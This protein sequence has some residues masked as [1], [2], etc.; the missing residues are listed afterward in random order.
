[1]PLFSESLTVPDCEWAKHVASITESGTSGWQWNGPKSNPSGFLALGRP[2]PYIPG[3]LFVCY[4]LKAARDKGQ[5]A[6]F[7]CVSGPRLYKL[8]STSGYEWSSVLRAQAEEFLKVEQEQRAV[9]ICSQLIQQLQRH[10]SLSDAD[11][12]ELS[13]LLLLQRLYLSKGQEAKRLLTTQQTRGTQSQAVEAALDTLTSEM[14]ADVAELIQSANEAFV[15]D[16]FGIWLS[17][18]SRTTGL[19]SEELYNALKNTQIQTNAPTVG[20]SAREIVLRQMRRVSI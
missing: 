8:A 14:G 13:N 2:V 11:R 6:I 5:T 12:E 3:D 16:S 10:T 20:K 4:K 1:M 17:R 18:M 15:T 7:T 19:D 9:W